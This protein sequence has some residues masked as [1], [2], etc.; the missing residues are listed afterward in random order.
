MRFIY[1]LTAVFLFG[2]ASSSNRSSHQDQAVLTNDSATGFLSNYSLLQPVRTDD[3]SITKRYISPK[4]YD[5]QYANVIVEPVTFY[6]APESTDTL[7]VNTLAEITRYA[8]SV[9]AMAIQPSL[10]LATEPG[11]KTLRLK[12][13]I[14]GISTQDDK[15]AAYQYIPIA[16]LLTAASGKLNDVVVKIQIEGELSDSLTGEPIIL[17]TKSGL[18]ETITSESTPL[19]MDN[20]STLLNSWGTTLHDT[21]TKHFD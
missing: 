9:I 12:V 3:N 2:C 17:A 20:V 6:P 14:T 19:T 5:H 1:F 10:A 21:L 7:S 11:P 4:L 15:L 13:A 16:F 8:D 18:G